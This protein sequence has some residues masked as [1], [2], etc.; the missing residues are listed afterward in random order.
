MKFHIGK[1][2][3]KLKSQL[4]NVRIFFINLTVLLTIALSNCFQHK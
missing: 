2:K 4:E 1:E 3:E